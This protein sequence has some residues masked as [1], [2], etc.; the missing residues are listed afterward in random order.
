ML[1]I[2]I[3]EDD[4][5]FRGI[6]REY[7]EIILKEITNQFEII[8]FNCGEDLIENYPD[9]IDIYF[10]DIEMGK[11]TGMDVA[12]KIREKNDKSEIIFTTGLIDYIH[13]GYEVRAYRYLLKPIKFEKLKEHVKSC[14]EDIRKRSENNLIIRNKGEVYK[15]KID[16]I[17]F[18]EV[19]NKDIIIHTVNQS[20]NT[21][22]NMN[23]IEKELIKYNFYRC[24]KSF[25]VNMK[26]VEY[27]KQNIILVNSIEIPVSRYRIKDFKI[28]L[29]SVL[30][31]VIC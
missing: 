17:I 19:I 12:R 9:N 3:C 22:M 10:L 14:I 8:E 5:L 20:Y 4:Y 13:D 18:V 16:E 1:N 21:K 7:L 31:D 27:I 29:L 28:K 11:L 2:V 24:H 30:G 26:H 23:S 15:L 25:L 6:L